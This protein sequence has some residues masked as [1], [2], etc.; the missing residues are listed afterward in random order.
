MKLTRRNAVIAGLLVLGGRI[1]WAV[2]KKQGYPNDGN[3]LT[4]VISEAS[5]FVSLDQIRWLE[6]RRGKESIRLDTDEIWRALH[7]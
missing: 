1:S 6:V 4:N 3:N 7:E 5:I 2:K